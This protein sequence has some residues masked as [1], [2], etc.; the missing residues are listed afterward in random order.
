MNLGARKIEG[1]RLRDLPMVLRDEQKGT[2]LSFS[3]DC[4]QVV[5]FEGILNF[6]LAETCNVRRYLFLQLRK[7]L[8]SDETLLVRNP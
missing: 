3:F 6:N 2:A 5:E 7:S 1:E 8:G 4:N